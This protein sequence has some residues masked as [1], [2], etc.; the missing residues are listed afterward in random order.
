MC[1]S[2]GVAWAHGWL[3]VALLGEGLLL[4][5]FSQAG[6]LSLAI[7]GHVGIWLVRENVEW[8]NVCCRAVR[9]PQRRWGLSRVLSAPGAM[10]RGSRG[11]IVW[12]AGV[13]ADGAAHH[14][15]IRFHRVFRRVIAALDT[16]RRSAPAERPQPTFEPSLAVAIEPAGERNNHCRWE[17]QQARHQSRHGDACSA[18]DC[19]SLASENWSN[20][21]NSNARMGGKMDV[22][23]H[24]APANALAV[25]NLINAIG[26]ASVPHQN[27]NGLQVACLGFSPWILPRKTDDAATHS[28]GT[29]SIKFPHSQ[30][31]PRN[32]IKRPSFWD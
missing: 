21:S 16:R 15:C 32:A 24:V 27:G 6:M 8:C 18:I 5:L 17:A 14:R 26:L 10:S 28:R 22:A 3:F 4:M 19:A 30:P 13:L 1:C 9:Q 11:P 12:R 29:N 2:L 7:A 25:I 20:D 31:F 23:N